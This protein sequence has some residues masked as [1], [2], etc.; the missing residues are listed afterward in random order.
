[1]WP[2]FTI[3]YLVFLIMAQHLMTSVFAQPHKHL[4][5]HWGFLSPG[6]LNGVWHHPALTKL[7]CFQLYLFINYTAMRVF[8]WLSGFLVFFPFFQKGT[9]WVKAIKQSALDKHANMLP[10]KVELTDTS[11]DHPFTKRHLCQHRRLWNAGY[12]SARWGK[13]GIAL[14]LVY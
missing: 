6:S 13:C 9:H 7:G 14:S 1:M 8:V 4:H 11:T 2:V 5:S 10:I 3:S 12:V